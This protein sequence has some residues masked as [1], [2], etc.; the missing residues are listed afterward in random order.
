MSSHPAHLLRFVIALLSPALVSV[1]A[2]EPPGLPNVLLIIGD[3]M[4]YADV[5]FHGCTDIPTPHLD[6]LAGG[7]V[8][9]TNAYASAP[10]C[11]PSRAAL[12]TGRY[13]QRFGFESLPRGN[14]GLPT[15]QITLAD[16]LKAAGYATGLIGKWHLGSQPVMRPMRRGFDEF[17]GFLDGGH[18]Y[19]DPEGILRGDEPVTEMDYTTDAF[20][21]EALAFIERHSGR[22]WFLCLSFNAVHDPMHATPDRL[23]KFAHISDQRRRTYAAMMI[24]MDEAIGAVRGKLADTGQASRTLVIFINDNGGPTLPGT[25]INGSRNDPWRGSKRTLLEGGIRVPCL[26]A[27]P[28][29]IKPAVY[30]QPVI[31]MDLTATALAAA[32]LALRSEWKLDGVDLA[33][34]LDG[35]RGGTPHEALYWRFGEQMAIRAGPYK[36]VRYD[37]NA[38][39]R[40]GGRTQ[41]VTEMKLY[42]LGRDPGETN[43]LAAIEPERFAELR[44]RWEA[45]NATLMPPLWDNMRAARE[46]ARV[47]ASPDSPR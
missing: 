21:R 41:P 33:P 17:F 32:G 24:A 4:G 18:S 7:G 39:T 42:H 5:G 30:D 36:L 31:M 15:D 46:R 34:F 16:R 28:G 29:T 19:F 47:G 11:S 2:T 27:W 23:E 6:A 13:Q 12:L 20:G 38:D 37:S 25:T 8:K 9:F 22:P 43:D 26:L 45:W 3:D 40:L 44:A 1:V 10:V 14:Q 35:A